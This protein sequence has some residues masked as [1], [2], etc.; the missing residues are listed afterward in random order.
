MSAEERIKECEFNL[1]QIKHFDPDPYYVNH[2]FTLFIKCVN[3]TY[4]Q[5]FKEAN[6][7]FGLFVLDNCNKENFLQKAF[8]KNE[9]KA[10]EFVN[11][12]EKKIEKE[13]ESS[14]PNFIKYVIDHQKKF[15]K[16][17]K[18]KIMM[19]AKERFQNDINHEIKVNL[20]KGRLRSKEELEI[21]IK[22]NLPIFLEI[23]NHKRYSNNEPKIN[24]TQITTSTF[25]QNN[26]MD[27]FEIVYASE[28]YIPV[29]KRILIESR[30]K[31]KEN[32]TWK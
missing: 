21:E 1:N 19:R 14:Y 22:R 26:Q 8:I 32:I 13:H 30:E 10:I 24:K 2:F 4:D 17:P 6:D 5:I 29:L 28:I 31:I 20:V 23:I 12:F 25:I 18:I 11:W 3:E 15:N 27:D 7:D 9:Q 16:L